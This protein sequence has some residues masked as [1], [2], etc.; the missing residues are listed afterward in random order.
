MS[1]KIKLDKIPLF[2]TP[3]WKASIDPNKDSNVNQKLLEKIL[4]DKVS[5]PQ[6]SGKKWNTPRNLHEDPEL[7]DFNEIVL[8]TAR[9]S[10][11]SIHIRY[12]DIEI[13]GCWAN[14]SAPGVTHHRHSHPNNYLSGVYYVQADQGANTIT[15]HDPRPT[16][17][18]IRPP[19]FSQTAETA[20]VTHVAVEP[21][22]LIF[23]PHW[24]VH[25]VEENKS[26]RDRISIAFNIMFTDYMTSMVKPMW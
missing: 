16:T 10:L 8:Y 23:F 15:F 14:V 19:M 5:D 6:L 3:L 18:L 11:D 13:T 12:T 1:I 26:N 22:D 21:G 20:E 25:S 17:G 24:L 4:I 7:A 2:P 9:L